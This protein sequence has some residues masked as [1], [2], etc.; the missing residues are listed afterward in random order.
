ML[1]HSG[2]KRILAL[3]CMVPL[4]LLSGCNPKNIKP[5]E[6]GERIGVVLMHGKDS[7]TTRPVD[8]LA[9]SLR[10]AGV[11]V[12][13]PLM[14]WTRD[15]IYDKTFEDSLLE[16]Q[17]YVK[18]LRAQGAT[19]VY[20]AGHSLGA[21]TSAGYGARIGDVDGIILLAPGHFTSQAGFRSHFVEELQTAGA[22]IEAGQGEKKRTFRD[23][24]SGIPATRYITARIYQ[25]WFSPTGPADFV[26][27]M[28]NISVAIPL[29][30]VAGSLDRIPQTQNRAYAFDK[31]P[32]HPKSQFVIIPA[33]HGEVPA[34]ADEIV[35]EWLR[36]L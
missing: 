10:T 7:P 4:F 15:R 13:T 19:R 12:V 34:K 16:I 18:K 33:T 3:A 29:L 28:S 20:L 30:Y 11:K 35:I 27:N 1:I 26:A 31:V 36:G 25:S 2:L 8:P 17:G 5:I 21:V 14:P 6:G 22:M 23:I 32:R 24:N 9:A